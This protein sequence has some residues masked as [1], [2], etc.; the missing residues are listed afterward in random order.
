MSTRV[1]PSNIIIYYGSELFDVVL[2]NHG[3]NNIIRECDCAREWVFIPA[4]QS[5]DGVYYIVFNGFLWIILMALISELYD[6]NGLSN[7]YFVYDIPCYIAINIYN[8]MYRYIYRYVLPI[9]YQRDVREYIIMTSRSAAV[10]ANNYWNV[11]KKI[12]DMTCTVMKMAFN[13]Y[14]EYI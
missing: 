14:S 12:I 10:V 7:I 1:R 3:N 4:A 13:L 2:H 9:S 6:W 8:I 11:V 5:S